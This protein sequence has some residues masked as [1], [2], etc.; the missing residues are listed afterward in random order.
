[1]PYYAAYYRLIENGQPVTSCAEYYA[2]TLQSARKIATQKAKEEKKT[3]MRL[4]TK[5]ITRI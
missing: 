3:F 5:P 2:K 4:E 1:M